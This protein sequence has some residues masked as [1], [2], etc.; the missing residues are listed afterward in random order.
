MLNL[1]LQKVQQ[2][3]SKASF[4][5]LCRGKRELNIQIAIRIS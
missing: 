2:R 3:Q 1:S 4:P 5:S